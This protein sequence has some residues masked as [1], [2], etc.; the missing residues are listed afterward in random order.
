MAKTWEDL[1]NGQWKLTITDDLAP[2]AAA[3]F[4]ITPPAPSLTL[5]AASNIV[6]NA[7]HRRFSY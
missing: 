7:H 2:E 3:T 5:S 1:G 6:R 4:T